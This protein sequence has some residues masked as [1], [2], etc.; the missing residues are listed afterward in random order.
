MTRRAFLAG[1]ISSI[2]LASAG[3]LTGPSITPTAEEKQQEDE[4][5]NKEFNPDIEQVTRLGDAPGISFEMTPKREYEYLEESD[6]VRI[7]YDSGDSST[8]PFGKFGTLRAVDHSSDRLQQILEDNSLTGTG[9]STG[10]GRV[11]SA[12]IDTSNSETAPVRAEFSR[13]VP[14]APIVFH[15]HHYARDGSLISEP[16]IT[17]EEIVATVPRSID[18]TMRFPEKRYTAVL[19]GVCTKDWAKNE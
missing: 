7:Q 4:Q 9:I 15:S 17:F 11:K 5:N 18:V 8:M 12:E 10:E 6:R 3:C 13:D 1:V 19:P 14:R 16:D 2:T